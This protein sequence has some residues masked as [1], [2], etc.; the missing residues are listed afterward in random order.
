MMHTLTFI[1]CLLF[2]FVGVVEAGPYLGD[3]K[4]GTTIYCHWNTN[5]AAGASIVRSTDG[6][7]H[8]YKDGA[9]GT[10]VTTGVTDTE[11][12]DGEV[13][14][15]LVAVATSD[16]FYASGNEYSIILKDAVIDTQ[17]V[18]AV[19]CQFSIGRK[20]DQ[21]APDGRIVLKKGTTSAI[22]LV[23]IS[24]ERTGG[25]L[26]GLVFNSSGLT[27]YRAR[28]DDG[29]AAGTAMTLATATRG[30]YTSLGFIEKDATNMP[31]WYEFGVPTACAASGSPYCVV[32]FQGVNA[33]KPAKLFIE[34][35]DNTATDSVNLLSVT[36]MTELSQATP[37]ATPT[38][39]DA[40]MALYMALRN[41][42]L[43][44]SGQISYTNDA[45]TVIFKCTLAD[46]GTT[47][48]K[49]ECLTG[50]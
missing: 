39:Q 20:K 37:S 8:V 6:T 5:S 25:P 26:T 10:E 14:V 28:S 7:I 17:A 47:F 18:S 30:T 31:G 32:H 9:T 42:T 19:L 43:T 36:G 27:A 38:M 29:N 12:F 3:F 41:S 44:T 24:D 1:V 21:T 11:S 40:L 16:A 50:P 49:A 35:V 48:T 13:G 2:A 46:D 15:N 4:P 34:L 33:M 45:G 22:A 23:Y